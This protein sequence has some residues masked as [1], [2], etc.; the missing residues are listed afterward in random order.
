MP[1]ANRLLACALL[2]LSVGCA[3]ASRTTA[4]QAD[5]QAVIDTVQGLF[6]AFATKDE[7]ALRR[8]F[9]PEA[10]IIDIKPGG[11]VNVREGGVDAEVRGIVNAKA[12]LEERLYDPDVHVSGDLATLWAAYDF[13]TDGQLSHCGTDTVQ[14]VRGATGWRILVLTFTIETEGCDRSRVRP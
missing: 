10:Q 9:H 5:K 8:L 7:Q 2:L 12:A 1:M 11:V 3:S 4:R 14:L 6:D 13:L